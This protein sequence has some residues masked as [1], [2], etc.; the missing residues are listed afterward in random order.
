MQIGLSVFGEAGLT[1]LAV[2]QRFHQP[3][4]NGVGGLDLEEGLVRQKA[5]LPWAFTFNYSFTYGIN[6]NLDYYRLLYL[7]AQKY[8]QMMEELAKG[9]KT[10]TVYLP[11]EATNVMGSIGG[12]KELFKGE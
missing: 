9:D 6:D 10:K 7:L 11:Y 3:E 4:R 1:H 8:I 12:I 2:L 5:R